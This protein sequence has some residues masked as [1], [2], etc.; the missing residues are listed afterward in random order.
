MVDYQAKV[1]YFEGLV[2]AKQLASYY[3]PGLVSVA[4]LMSFT[5][6]STVCSGG[7]LVVRWS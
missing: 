6:E 4:S 2:A 7:L 5:S 1:F 3:F